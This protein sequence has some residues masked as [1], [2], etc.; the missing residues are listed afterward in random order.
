VKKT[1][2]I[3]HIIAI[4]VIFADNIVL[5]QFLK[6]NSN[7]IKDKISSV[8]FLRKFTSTVIRDFDYR[9][10]DLPENKNC[11]ENEKMIE[12]IIDSIGEKRFQQQELFFEHYRESG[13]ILSNTIFLGDLVNEFM[14]TM[15]DT[16]F[17]PFV[18][19]NE[20]CYNIMDTQWCQYQ[21]IN[22][23]VFPISVRLFDYNPRLSTSQYRELKKSADVSICGKDGIVF[24]LVFGNKADSRQ[25]YY[26]FVYENEAFV[27][28]GDLI[29]SG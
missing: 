26:L 22:L 18:G 8:E 7:Y 29:R 25:P 14:D 5:F 1:L 23:F 6:K 21:S 9:K 15:I 4:T 3:I 13:S 10:P 11:L 19:S 20:Y 27:C 28:T 12:N 16:L 24:N 2:L 17:L